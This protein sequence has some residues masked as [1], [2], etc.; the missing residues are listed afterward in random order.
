MSSTATGSRGVDSCLISVAAAFTPSLTSLYHAKLHYVHINAT[1][2]DL[3]CV[4][5]VYF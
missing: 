1:T 4:F 5:L 2:S 3:S